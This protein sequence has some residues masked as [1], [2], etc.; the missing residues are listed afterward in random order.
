MRLFGLGR[1]SAVFRLDGGLLP[2]TASWKLV[3]TAPA[4]A[5][6]HPW[7]NLL[8]ILGDP[9]SLWRVKAR[10]CVFSVWLGYRPS[11]HP[12]RPRAP[13]MVL[14]YYVNYYVGVC[15]F[16]VSEFLEPLPM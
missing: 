6:H 12:S 10:G 11:A 4:D 8:A 16:Q 9:L 14:R 7:P 3:E 15:S 5:T 13:A 1:F 2:G